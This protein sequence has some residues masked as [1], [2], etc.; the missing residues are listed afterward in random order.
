MV[1]NAYPLIYTRTRCHDFFNGFLVQPSQF[2][3]SNILMYSLNKVTDAMKNIENT[4]DII[5][6]VV[7]NK[8]EYIVCG[9]SC[10]TPALAKKC[11]VNEND[12]FP[13]TNKSYNYYLRDEADRK[14]QCFIGLVFKSSDL[15]EIKSVPKFNDLKIFLDLFFKYTN[16]QWGR[17]VVKT[18]NIDIPEKIEVQQLQNILDISNEIFND[19]TYIFEDD[20]ENSIQ[21]YFN[22][23]SNSKNDDLSIIYKMVDIKEDLH[24]TSFT[25]I[26]T[27]KT[28][29]ESIKSSNNEAKL[30]ISTPIYDNEFN[31]TIIDE[32]SK[33][34]NSS[35]KNNDNFGNTLLGNINNKNQNKNSNNDNKPQNLPGSNRI[36]SNYNSSTSNPITGKIIYHNH[37]LVVIGLVAI[38]IVVLLILFLVREYITK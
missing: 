15:L 22:K 28:L 1:V 35:S 24:N 3:N 26:V 18:E 16:N 13:N 27:S 38:I 29:Y 5:R 11:G 30:K 9:I 14:I 8:E 17:K 19:K 6:Q 25:D 34:S 32:K 23:L 21:Y 10:T 7:F 12:I 4:N 37:P 33:S 31:N 36:S 2:Q 20:I